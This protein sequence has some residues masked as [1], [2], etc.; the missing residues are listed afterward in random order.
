MKRL[1]SLLLV[2]TLAACAAP[3]AAPSATVAVASPTPTS[4]SAP[5]TAAPTAATAAPTASPTLIPLP[6]VAQ[7][8]A[9]SGTVIWALVANTRLFRSTDRGDTWQ[10]RPLPPQAANP[11]F[12]F[13][14]DHQGWLAATGSPA[15]QCQTQSFAL[16]H[17]VDAGASW[18]P[19]NVTGIAASQCK[20]NVTFSDASN[21][22]VM[23]SAPSSAPAA[24]RSTDGGQSWILRPLPLAP[25][26]T[27]GLVVVSVRAFASTVLADVAG[28][29]AHYSYRSSDGGATWTYLSTAP[30]QQDAIAF[31]TATRWLQISSPGN[32]KETVDAGA[33]W[34][35]FTTDYQQA[36]PVAPAVTFGD[37]QVGYATVRGAIQRTVDGGAHWTAIRTPGTF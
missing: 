26:S 18:Q 8:S 20:N 23:A 32:S 31:V 27:G 4:T 15:T 10:E 16:S 36:A 12:S 5:T 14:D 34:H 2:L 28:P 22:L 30:D 24:Y 6:N 7:I 9:P 3:A 29:T 25:G 17:T 19:V 33:S 11:L 1:T 21:G 13:I 37:A 35:A